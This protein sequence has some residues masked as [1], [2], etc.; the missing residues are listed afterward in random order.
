M[1]TPAK[2]VF[3]WNVLRVVALVVIINIHYIIIILIV[4][5]MCLQALQNCEKKNTNIKK[6]IS[7]PDLPSVWTS[8]VL[9]PDCNWLA[10]PSEWFR[11]RCDEL[12]DHKGIRVPST[13]KVIVSSAIYIGKRKTGM[14]FINVE[15]FCGPW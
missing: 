11:L 1:T 14:V 7:R 15:Y 8:H 2:R 6:N 3:R 4:V 9:S 13:T 5:V 12:N 10:N